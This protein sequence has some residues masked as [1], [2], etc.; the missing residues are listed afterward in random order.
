[1]TSRGFPVFQVCGHHVYRTKTHNTHD[2][3]LEMH[4]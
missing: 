2:Y 4:R 1:M 3:S